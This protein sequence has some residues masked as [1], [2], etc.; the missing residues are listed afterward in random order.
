[1]PQPHVTGHVLPSTKEDKAGEHSIAAV[2][3]FPLLAA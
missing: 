3:E 2:D 1:M